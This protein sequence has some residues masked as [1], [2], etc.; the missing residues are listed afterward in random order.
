MSVASI[1]GFITLLGIATRNGVMLIAHI[2]RLVE[3]EGVTDPIVAVVRG[4]LERLALILMTALAAG[5]ALVPVAGARAHRR[6]RLRRPG[7]GL[8]PCPRHAEPR[9]RADDPFGRIRS[10]LKQKKPQL[11]FH[12]DAGKRVPLVRDG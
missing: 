4:A 6:G 2:H 12:F 9:H 3:Q 11:G 8:W 10:A 5:L 1:I 7:R